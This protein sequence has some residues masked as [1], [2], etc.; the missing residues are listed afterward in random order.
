MENSIEIFIPESFE[1][2]L[3]AASVRLGYL[4]PE[5]VFKKSE[6]G[7]RAYWEAGNDAPCE[8]EIR[9]NALHQVYRER[10][11]AET[12]PIRKWINSSHDVVLQP[13]S[14]A[15]EAG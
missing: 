12:L 13:S 15:S 2:Y 1:K 6:C 8:D 7:I 5:I 3:D 9:K 10:I 11:F 14:L 4:H